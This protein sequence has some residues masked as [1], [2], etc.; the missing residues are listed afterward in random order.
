MF[1]CLI[2]NYSKC[3]ISVPTFV[4]RAKTYN[5]RILLYSWSHPCYIFFSQPPETIKESL[6]A[7]IKF[8]LGE[9]FVVEES[10]PMKIVLC[11]I[12]AISSKRLLSKI[13]YSEIGMTRIQ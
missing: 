8:F 6:E 12:G 9:I 1:F 13:I 3:F 2:A 10:I 11:V 4:A 7:Y 5:I